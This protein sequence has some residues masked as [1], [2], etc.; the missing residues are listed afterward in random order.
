MHTRQQ[1]Q[2]WRLPMQCRSKLR[3]IIH[4]AHTYQSRKV[5]VPEHNHNISSVR[6]H[7]VQFACRTSHLTSNSGYQERQTDA[8]KDRRN[9]R[10][11]MQELVLNAHHLLKKEPTQGHEMKRF[12]V[13]PGAYLVLCIFTVRRSYVM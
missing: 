12:C 13:S 8:Y 9:P 11:V 10:G 2:K 6:N 4:T 7:G 3:M 5:G 1:L